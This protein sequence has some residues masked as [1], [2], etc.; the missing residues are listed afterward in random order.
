MVATSGQ[1]AGPGQPA[2]TGDVEHVEW[3]GAGKLWQGALVPKNVFHG[4]PEFLGHRDYLHFVFGEIKQRQVFLQ[5]EENEMVLVRV[6]QREGAQQGRRDIG[7][8]SHGFAAPGLRMWKCRFAF[9]EILVC[10]C[11]LGADFHWSVL[12]TCHLI[13]S[14]SPTP[15]PSPPGRG[16]NFVVHSEPCVFFDLIQRKEFIGKL[17]NV[18]VSYQPTGSIQCLEIILFF[19]PENIIP[20]VA[21]QVPGARGINSERLALRRSNRVGV[22]SLQGGNSPIARGGPRFARRVANG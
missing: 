17:W 12:E 14:P 22:H 11:G 18:F 5:H 8:C 19:S 10:E 3:Q 1:G 20:R 13:T 9:C 16:R 4:R 2:I 6:E 21:W 15:R 7:R